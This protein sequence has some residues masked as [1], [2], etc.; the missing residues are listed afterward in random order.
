MVKLR[1]EKKEGLKMKDKNEIESPSEWKVRV[2]SQLDSWAPAVALLLVVLVL[3]GGWMTYTAYAVEPE[4]EEKTVVAA[5]WGTNP[6]FSHGAVVQRPNPLYEV[7]ET[8]SGTPAY[9]SRIT[10]N[11]TGIYTFQYSASE[12]GS[13]DVETEVEMVMRETGQDGAIYWSQTD[14]LVD[15]EE[16]GVEP[17]QR[18]RTDFTVNVTEV[19]RR[20]SE[21]RSGLGTTVGTEEVVLFLA[22]TVEGEVNGEKVNTGERHSVTLDTDGDVYRV[23]NSEG[24]EGR[25]FQTNETV[26]VEPEPDGASMVLSPLLLF[27][28]LSFLL[29]LTVAKYKDVIA[30][31]ERELLAMERQEFDEWISTG[32]LSNGALENGRFVVHVDSI[33]GVV[34]IAIDCGERVIEDRDENMLC[35]MRDNVVYVYEY[36]EEIWKKE[37]GSGVIEEG[38]EE[39]EG[40][41]VEAEEYE[42]EAVTVEEFEGEDG[43]ADTAEKAGEGDATAEGTENG[44]AE[45]E[46]GDDMTGG[47][48]EGLKEK[49]D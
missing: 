40:M 44:D 49:D 12:G 41:D 47:L 5:E 16:T 26:L 7:G 25:S 3:A 6:G 38:I 32:R 39:V 13:L 1:K 17:G 14:T 33:E 34:D 37:D 30:P 23:R 45:D 46:E 48:F 42:D 22:T 21:I 2:R 24:M 10:P 31:T 11:L 9:Y 43:E 35:V 4:P 20:I 29:G 18:V 36:D 27:V 19:R 15:T 8:V 28:S